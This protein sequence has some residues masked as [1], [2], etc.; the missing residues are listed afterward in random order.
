MEYQ[1]TM[2]LEIKNIASTIQQICRSIHKVIHDD[3]F[4]TVKLFPTSFLNQCKKMNLRIYQMK[5][6]Q[7]LKIWLWKMGCMRKWLLSTEG[8]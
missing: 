3:Y 5:S 1:E 7:I 8:I 4:K 2:N 6:K